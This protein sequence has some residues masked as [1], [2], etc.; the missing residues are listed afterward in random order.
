MDPCPATD[1]LEAL[2][3]G[4][5]ADHQQTTIEGHVERCA[6][7]QARLAELTE[8]S[9]GACAGA[10]SAAEDP[11]FLA[12]LKGATPLSPAPPAPALPAPAELVPPEAAAVLAPAFPGYELLGELRAGAAGTVYR[13]RH[14]A[15]ERIVVL[16]VFLVGKGVGSVGRARFRAGAAAVAA[17]RH[18][19]L[20]RIYETGASADRIYLAREFVEGEDLAQ[21]LRAGP[22]PPAEAVTMARTVAR[23]LHHA[24]E[25]GVGHGNLK[26]T[27]ILLA[28]T[29]VPKLADFGL[30]RH[31]DSGEAAWRIIATPYLAPEQA[32][33]GKPGPAAD[34]YALGAVLYECLTGRPPFTGADWLQTV[35]GSAAHLPAPPQVIRPGLA[36]E[37]AAICL[38]CLSKDPASRP[39]TAGALADDLD[40]FLSLAN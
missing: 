40:R 10:H 12:R 13:A 16:K 24:H 14:T 6:A 34:V 25:R 17:L 31:L 11:S 1:S 27:N 38:R 21:R 39:T 7:C 9:W 4:R 15:S 26:P 32:D 22:L 8:T 5:L 30:A 23:A 28:T 2:L 3:A 19:N 29:G 33:G 20:A 36:P 37:L 18:D 35:R